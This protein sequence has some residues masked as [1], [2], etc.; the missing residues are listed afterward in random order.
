MD[1]SER[2]QKL[3]Q[4]LGVDQ[5]GMSKLTGIDQSLISRAR[6]GERMPSPLSCLCFAALTRDQDD[7]E[8]WLQICRIPEK[9]R[10]LIVR[11]LSNV[12]LNLTGLPLPEARLLADILASGDPDIK[13]QVRGILRTYAHAVKSSSTARRAGGK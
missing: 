7:R 8:Y 3:M 2:L 11:A 10:E 6:S 1:Y 9:Q 4:E 5:V 13:A 12:P